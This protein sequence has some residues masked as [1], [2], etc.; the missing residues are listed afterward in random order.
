[1]NIARYVV[2]FA[3]GMLLGLLLSTLLPSLAMWFWS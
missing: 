1:M 2:F 3:L